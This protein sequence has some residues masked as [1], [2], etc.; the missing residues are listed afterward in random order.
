MPIQVKR[1]PSREP[2]RLPET[3]SGTNGVKLGDVEPEG[4]QHVATDVSPWRGGGPTPFSLQPPQGRQKT[5]NGGASFHRVWSESAT[6][7]RSHTVRGMC[8]NR[9]ACG[10]QQRYTFIQLR[11]VVSGCRMRA[12]FFRV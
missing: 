8:G 10:R 7:C 12:L 6:E 3:V 5:G 11:I 2:L 1:S 9:L 4:R